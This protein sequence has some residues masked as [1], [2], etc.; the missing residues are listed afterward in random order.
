MKERKML[1]IK[2]GITRP[3]RWEAYNSNK[4]CNVP[5][6]KMGGTLTNL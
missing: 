6:P 2:V 4:V 1:E 3:I 5:H